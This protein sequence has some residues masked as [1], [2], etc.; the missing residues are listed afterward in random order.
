MAYEAET[1]AALE[2]VRTASRVAGAVQRRLLKS[3]TLAKQDKSPVTVADFAVQAIVC[4]ELAQHFPD[5]PLVGEESAELLREPEQGALCDAVV[6]EV[7]AAVPGQPGKNAVLD[8]IDLGAPSGAFSRYW[9]LDPIDGTKGFMRGAQYA[10]A[11]ALIEDGRVQAGVLGCPNLPY[12]PDAPGKEGSVGALFTARRGAGAFV[13]SLAAPERQRPA[14]VDACSDPSAARFCE[15]VDPG[16]SHQERAAA[17]AA[18]LGITR[19]PFRIDS[20]CKYACVAQGDASIYLRLPTRA[21]YREKI[22][23]HAAGMIVVEEA[24]GRVSDTEGAPLDF[25]HGEQLENNRGVVA[26]SGPLH[27]RVLEVLASLGD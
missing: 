1:R 20:Q 23:D 6:R 9:T 15:S 25:R 26:T 12:A 18:A 22:W 7:R 8:W 10:V 14:Q 5:D 21:G 19:E 17:V 27:D 4:R 3:E 13:A 11:L 2:A 24:G 16:H